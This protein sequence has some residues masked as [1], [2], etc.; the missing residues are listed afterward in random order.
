MPI[1]SKNAW[2]DRFYEQNKT[3]N[4]DQV[5]FDAMA[6]GTSSIR[7]GTADER[8]ADALTDFDN[9]DS[10]THED[11][12][13]EDIQLDNADGST[14]EELQ[15]RS[16]LLRKDYPFQIHRNSL[17]YSPPAGNSQ[18]YEA[19]LCIAKA[20]NLTTGKYKYL[21]RYFEELSCL[22][23]EIYLGDHA[24]AYRT[25]WPRPKVEPKRL[26]GVINKLR[27]LTGNKVG[28][29]RWNPKEGRPD[30]PPPS[31][32]KDCG[33]DLVAWKSS[34]DN[35][36]GQL[37]MYGQCACGGN[38]LSDDK[39][40]E[41]RYSDIENWVEKPIIDPVYAFFTPWHATDGILL[42]A[43]RLAGLIFD[44]ARLV[45]YANCS[46]KIKQAEAQSIISRIINTVHTH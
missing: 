20:E 1:K 33:L 25:G 32:V 6:N 23:S 5:E 16:D 11:W 18:V 26:K 41:L 45:L 46:P 21:P 3:I 37:Y 7:V 24:N 43:S 13:K 39:M 22:V 9:Q 44:R 36:T 42:E 30:D 8:I 28:E 17:Q 2:E 15:R 38:W 14:L 27:A 19:L 10:L 35:R 12:E 40:C 29:W 4:A 31:H 34:I